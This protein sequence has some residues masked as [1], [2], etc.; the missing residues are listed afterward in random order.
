MGSFP[1][2]LGRYARELGL[3]SVEEA[4]RRMT[5]LPARRVGLWDRGLLRPGMAADV[6]VFDPDTIAD[7]ATFEEPNVYSEGVDTVVVNGVV[8][9]AG[10]RMTGERGGRPLLRGR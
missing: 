6:V 1:R 4:V 9:L 3:F 8:T 10:G 2:I 7:R 5:S